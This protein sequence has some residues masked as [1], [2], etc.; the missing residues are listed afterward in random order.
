MSDFIE[1]CAAVSTE[2]LGER[3]TVTIEPSRNKT[4]II[5][6]HGTHNSILHLIITAES[7]MWV[8]ALRS[9]V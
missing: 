6:T 7:L 1:S 5:G 8:V 3:P 2:A 4:M 9:H